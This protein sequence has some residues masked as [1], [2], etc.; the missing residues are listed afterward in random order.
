MGRYNSLRQKKLT[1]ALEGIQ[2]YVHEIDDFSELADG[3]ILHNFAIGDVL[4]GID[5]VNTASVACSA[6]VLL[7]VTGS[8]SA[9]LSTDLKALASYG[10]ASGCTATYFSEADTLQWKVTTNACTVGTTGKVII[11]KTSVRS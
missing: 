4:Q 3:D 7:L 5:V 6:S 1:A 11:R 8:A 10:L 2:Q 9:T